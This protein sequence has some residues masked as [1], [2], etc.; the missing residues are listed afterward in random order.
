MG[1][2]YGLAHDLGTVAAIVVMVAAERFVASYY[3]LN[4]YHR[5]RHYRY[6]HWRNSGSLVD[7]S[8]W[9]VGHDVSVAD[10]TAQ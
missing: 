3:Y 8:Y 7:D 10:E 2:Q 9:D 5:L 6:A 1:V 4:R